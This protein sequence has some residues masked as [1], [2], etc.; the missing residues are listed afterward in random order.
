M[1]CPT[2]CLNLYTFLVAAKP[3]GPQFQ[4]L[5]PHIDNHQVCQKTQVAIL[6]AGVA[7]ITA[8]VSDT[9]HLCKR[10]TN[11]NFQQALSNEGVD[12]FLLV[13]Y[14]DEIGGRCRAS[15]FGKDQE[16]NPYTVEIGANWV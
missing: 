14:N 8:A 1:W 12:D 13:E 6:G 15:Q 11:W 3:S 9:S 16:G 5:N 7:G 4:I 2:L 10:V